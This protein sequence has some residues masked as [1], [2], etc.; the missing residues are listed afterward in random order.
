MLG[1]Y[2]A[3]IW[4]SVN[5]KTVVFT[6]EVAGFGSR[7]IKVNSTLGAKLGA[8]FKSTGRVDRVHSQYYA[9]RQS[10][11]LLDNF[12][13]AAAISATAKPRFKLDV[14]KRGRESPAADVVDRPA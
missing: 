4:E 3:L 12:S 8:K 14:T 2:G 10:Q 5:V 11:R 7:D 1:S 13:A 9:R 6:P